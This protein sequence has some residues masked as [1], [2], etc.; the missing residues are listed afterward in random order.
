MKLTHLA[1][2]KVIIARLSPVAGS[3]TKI[4]LTTVT[5]ALGHLQPQGRENYQM[6]TG[7]TGKNYVIYVDGGT[8]I[9]E[10][11][12]L[13]DESGNIY[14]VRAGGVTRWQHGAMDYYEVYL[15]QK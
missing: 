10:N 12:Q 6:A 11:D 1:N 15:T 3:S 4:A 7:I 2:Q 5:A 14:T 9:Q 13:K 8:D